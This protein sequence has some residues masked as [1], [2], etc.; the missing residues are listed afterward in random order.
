MPMLRRKF[1]FHLPFKNFAFS[2]SASKP[3]IGGSFKFALRIA[4]SLF[5]CD[6]PTRVHGQRGRRKRQR[7]RTRPTASRAASFRVA[8]V[9]TLRACCGLQHVTTVAGLTGTAMSRASSA[10]AA[11]GLRQTISTHVGGGAAPTAL[12]VRTPSREIVSEPF[13]GMVAIEVSNTVGGAGGATAT[14]CART[15][16]ALAL[17]TTTFPVI[18][19]KGL[20]LLPVFN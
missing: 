2:L 4:A 1:D 9:T 15:L 3:D 6:S 5:H 14:S 16:T 12:G 7:A 10:L 13:A 18:T 20:R 11:E 8:A 19:Q 17:A